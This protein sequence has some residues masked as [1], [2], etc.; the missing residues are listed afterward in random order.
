MNRKKPILYS[1]LIILS[2]LG[3]QYLTI[4]PFYTPTALNTPNEKFLLPKFIAHKSIVSDQA[5]GNSKEAILEALKTPIEGI[6]LDVRLSKDK[7]PFIYHAD[8]LDVSHGSGRPEEK[9]W[10]E[11]QAITLSLDEVFEIVGNEKYLFL[12]IK[13]KGILNND[14]A[15]KIIE[16]IE[17][18]QISDT[19][20]VE[21]LNPIFLIYM[22]L[23]ARDIMIMYDFVTD[24]TAIGEEV[25]SQFDSIPWLLKQNFIQ[26]QFRR[27]LRPDI[28][29]PRWNVDGLYLKR[30]IAHGYPVIVWTVDDTNVA[31]KLFS[32]GITG[33]QSNKAIQ[34]MDNFNVELPKNIMDA[35]GTQS[36]PEKVIYVTK[37]EDIQKALKRA[38]E[39]NQ[40]I[41]IAG[42]RHSMGGQSLLSAGIQLNMLG[43]NKVQ[44]NL[45][46]QRVTAEAG[47]TWKKI[48]KTLDK[49]QR[50]VKI[51]QSDNIFTVG[52]SISVNIHGWQVAMPPLSST[53]NSLKVMTANGLI[54]TVSLNNEPELFRAIIGGY[55][56]FSVILEA[57]LETTENTLLKSHHKV[58]PSEQFENKFEQLLSDNP[59]VELAY[60]RFSVD[61]NNLLTE[62][63]LN[64]YERVNSDTSI[65]LSLQ[66]EKY[67]AIKRAIFRASEY[68]D[69]GKRVR[70]TAE[71]RLANELENS[72]FSRN[73]IMN[74]DIHVLWPIKKGNIDILQ[75][76][77]IPKGKL[78]LFLDK[79]RIYL[80]THPVNLL[81]AT[82][83]DV[84]KDTISALPYANHNSFAI[85]LLFSQP[86]DGIGEY[87]MKEFTAA[88]I[89]E[90]LALNGN[91]YL[92]YRPHYTY[93]ELIQ[94]YPTL[95]NWF[96]LKK[97]YDPKMLFNSEF[98]DFIQALRNKSTK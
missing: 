15:D 77:F 11:L 94:A 27:I 5:I 66:P 18:H 1:L 38:Q 73:T 49:H 76:Y 19:V 34:I 86:N 93:E 57:E 26:K 24:A 14:F 10:S 28:L 55:G 48:Q 69:T 3:I 60:G 72:V 32:L 62:A 68:F 7:I 45:E 78:N 30:L 85:V 44:Y 21:S 51:M 13:E 37:I 42:K 16:L 29:G 23:S 39:N 22:R 90:V 35:G 95:S 61:Q 53:I 46:T 40:K 4:E 20:I 65:S 8:N 81:N 79:L 58:F 67:I 54:K 75:E 47:A 63:M 71:K 84:R 97:Q 88:F 59:N 41:S 50:A 6:E 98:I 87:N 74:T 9:N 56:Q 12:D 89:K 96:A 83:R 36:Y 2:V 33:L 17:K 70:W 64:W 52:G 31:V 82:I 92:P 43:F 25:Q 80:K 91:F